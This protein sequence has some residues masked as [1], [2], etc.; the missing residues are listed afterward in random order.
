MMVRS[1]LLSLLALGVF[2]GAAHAQNPF[3]LS[4]DDARQAVTGGK[5]LA[6]RDIVRSVRAQLPGELVDVLGLESR[7][8]RMVYR[9]RWKTA[10]GRIL[11]LDVDAETG[12]VL[13]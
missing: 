5:Q 2:S 3:R 6:L 11:D 13:R 4:P 8:Q 1:A 9:L 10:D 7:G 12:A